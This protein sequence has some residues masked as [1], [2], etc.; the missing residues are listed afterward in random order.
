MVLVFRVDH[1][2]PVP[3]FAS[4]QSS[5]VSGSQTVTHQHCLRAP[6]A[7][8]LT[9]P[10]CRSLPEQS[11]PTFL[12]CLLALPTCFGNARSRPSLQG[13]HCWCQTVAEQEAFPARRFYY[14][15]YYGRSLPAHLPLGVS[16]LFPG[17]KQ[18]LVHLPS[19]IRCA[20]PARRC[21][22]MRFVTIGSLPRTSAA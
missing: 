8:P 1:G 17:A 2:T 9:H 13:Q 20:G 11:T 18:L 4:K 16:S 10:V 14:G 15:I 19:H 7:S 5:P 12:M 6:R 22:S 3:E 21:D